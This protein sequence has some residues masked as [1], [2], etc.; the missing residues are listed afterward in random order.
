MF[1]NKSEFEFACLSSTC[2][3]LD[4]TSFHAFVLAIVEWLDFKQA[5]FWLCGW[6]I[7]KENKL[8]AQE[9]DFVH[10]AC[11]TRMEMVTFPLKWKNAL[12]NAWINWTID[13]SVV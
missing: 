13:Q 10:K 1:Y 6:S 12:D 3:F 5:C 2:D 9:A 7:L 4:K 11:F 8:G